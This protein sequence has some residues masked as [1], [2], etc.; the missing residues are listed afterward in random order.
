MLNKP[1]RF[2]VITTPRSGSTW[3]ATLLDSHSAIK[4]L[5]EPFIWRS[6]RPYWNEKIPTFFNYK[7][8]V[9]GKSFLSTFRYIDLMSDLYLNNETRV[10]GFKVMYN[11]LQ[12]HPSILIKLFIDRFKIIHLVRTNYLDILISRTAAKQHS[13]LHSTHKNFTKNNALEKKKVFICPDTLIPNLIRLRRN[14]KIVQFGLRLAP[15]NVLEISYEEMVS[16]KHKILKKVTNF[17]D[18]T[19]EASGFHSELKRIHSGGYAE[20]IQNYPEVKK[21]LL[22]SKFSYLIE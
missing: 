7:R 6:E 21:I 2:C 22:D 12:K 19:F 13:V 18:V 15:V 10:L 5:E 17:L 4:S 16:D 8:S 3:L 14:A 9:S 20:K 1:T 11:H